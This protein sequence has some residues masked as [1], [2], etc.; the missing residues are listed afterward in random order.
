MTFRQLFLLLLF[1]AIAL[2]GGFYADELLA[3]GSGLFKSP[4]PPKSR[5][6]AYC[7]SLWVNEARN[8]PALRCYLTKDIKRLCV[9]SEKIHL[10]YIMKKYVSD[11]TNY[12]AKLSGYI[13]G[14]Q[15]GLSQGPQQKADGTTETS[16]EQYSRVTRQ[17]A[18]ALKEQGFD[19]AFQLESTLDDDLVA[20]IRKLG[21]GGYMKES[22]YGWFAGDLVAQAY[23]ELG[24][25]PAPTC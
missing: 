13:M 2:A 24:P 18:Q 20:M 25:I 1:P 7:A 15:V 10:G 8:D 12:E 19:K 14:T 6:D 21:E 23:H 11:R 9:P 4:P 17:K 3:V 5:V 22:D 16:M